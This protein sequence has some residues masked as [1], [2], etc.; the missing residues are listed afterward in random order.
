MTDK[1]LPHTK[2]RPEYV[3]FAPSDWQAGCF[4]LSA[5]QEWT[6]LQISIYCMDKGQPVPENMIQRLLMRHGGEWQDDLKELIKDGKVHRTQGGGYFVKR[7]L[8]EY[9]R[10]DAALSKRRRAGK[11]GAEKRWNNKQS[12]SNANSNANSQANAM[13]MAEETRRD[14]KRRDKTESPSGDYPPKPPAD[15]FDMIDSDIWK[16]FIDHRIKLKAPM[17]D[18]AESMIRNKLE[19]I[20]DEQGHHPNAVLEQSIVRGW[21]GVFPIKDDG[22]NSGWSWANE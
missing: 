6:Y 9:E 8:V 1:E 4:M 19:Q 18:R 14:E 11:K 20:H 5:M 17:T 7:A 10:A 13:P 16:A 15:L 22:N 3:G 21:K 12:D 2:D